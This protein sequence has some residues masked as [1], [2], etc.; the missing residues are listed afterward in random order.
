MATGQSLLDLMAVVNQE[1]QTASG[2]ADVVRSLLALNAAQDWFETLLA[3]EPKLF[4]DT[5]GTVTTTVATERTAFPTDVRRV[6]ALWFIDPTTSLPLYQ[7]DRVDRTGGHAW[8]RHWPW[9]VI[10]NT[11]QGRPTQY[12]TDGNFIYWSPMPSGT[13]TIRW[14]G[15]QKAADITAVGTFAYPDEAMFP[16]AT[17]AARIMAA[18]VGDES[19][20]LQ[21]LAGTTFAPLIE[22]LS[23]FQRERGSDFQYRY[24]HD[25]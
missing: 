3:R 16:L 10:S 9:N 5:I 13:H 25:A 8:K 14:Y 18:G 12:W 20:D 6:D 7:L 15:F 19:L 4:G 2:E 22:E 17:F 11:V 1:L 21:S 24:V 23:K